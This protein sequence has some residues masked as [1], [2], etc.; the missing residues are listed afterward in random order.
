MADLSTTYL[1]STYLAC[2]ESSAELT[3]M[4]WSTKRS[5]LNG[6]SLCPGIHGW[7]A[8]FSRGIHHGLLSCRSVS[9]SM[10]ANV[11]CVSTTKTANLS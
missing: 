3:T 10:I 2:I 11:V 9:N 8:N 1:F 7:V 4:G 6:Q 5:L